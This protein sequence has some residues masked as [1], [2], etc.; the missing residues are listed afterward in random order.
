MRWFSAL[1]FGVVMAAVT[2]CALSGCSAGPATVATSVAAAAGTWRRAQEVPGLAAF[3]AGAR[4]DAEVASVSCVPGGNCAAGGFYKDSAGRQQAFVVAEAGGSW[5]IAD[6][7]PDLDALNA[8]GTS[9]VAS[10]SCASA[11]NCAAGGDYQDSAGHLQAF[12]V[13]ETRP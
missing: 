12:V 9:A 11:G 10:V 4:G 3:R 6:Q 2:C 8:G 13:D 7:V 1:V 5:G